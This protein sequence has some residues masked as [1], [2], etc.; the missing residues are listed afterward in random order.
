MNDWIQESTFVI[1]YA[2]FVFYSLG[3]STDKAAGEL[4]LKLY[5]AF[6]TKKDA[7][8]WLLTPNPYLNGRYPA[9]LI[10]N[11]NFRSVLEAF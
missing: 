11:G 5:E 6:A 10:I 9:T 2:D 1:S 7:D 4:F 8:A 3:V